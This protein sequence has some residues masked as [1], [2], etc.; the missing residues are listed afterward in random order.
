MGDIP[1]GNVVLFHLGRSE[2]MRQPLWTFYILE[3]VQIWP[4]GE[5]TVFE[6]HQLLK[7]ILRRITHRT[8]GCTKL[9][10]SHHLAAPPATPRANR[11]LDQLNQCHAHSVHHCLI[12]CIPEFCSFTNILCYFSFSCSTPARQGFLHCHKMHTWLAQL[13]GL[14]GRSGEAGWCKNSIRKISVS[15]KVAG[16]GG[17]PIKLIPSVV[18]HFTSN[19]PLKCDSC[20]KLH[21]FSHCT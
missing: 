1:C 12:S 18:A 8:F 2:C 3:I 4:L 7:F 6:T 16:G 19:L 17:R 20:I 9:P 5:S 10:I 15:W 21:Q 13:G 14:C 11:G